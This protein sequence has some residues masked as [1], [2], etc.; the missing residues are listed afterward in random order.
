MTQPAC[1]TFLPGHV[2]VIICSITIQLSNLARTIYLE[3][4]KQFYSKISNFAIMGLLFLSYPLLGYI[5]D[6]CL[7]RYRTLKCSFI[8][9]IVGYTIGLILFL[10]AIPVNLTE[11]LDKTSFFND[12]KS[13]TVLVISAIPLIALVTTGVA[14]IHWYYWTHNAVQLVAM[15]LAVAWLTTEASLKSLSSYEAHTISTLFSCC[16]QFSTFTEPI[17]ELSDQ[18][19]EAPHQNW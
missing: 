9:L 15:S 19:L 4:H 14:F 10:I 3:Q 1:R 5:A 8:F 2:V 18:L 13:Y 16:R 17:Q 7:T 12:D 6:V 11:I